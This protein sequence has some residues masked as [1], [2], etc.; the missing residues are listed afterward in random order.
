[1]IEL[2]TSNHLEAL[3]DALAGVVAEPLPSPFEPETIV[4]QSRGME[5][6]LSMRLAERFGLWANAEYPF[7]RALIQRVLEAAHGEEYDERS[8][9]DP[10][11]ATWS[12]IA[13]LDRAEGQPELAPLVDYLADDPLG[14]KRF[15]LADRI[16]HTFDQYLVYRP[17]M[18][19]EWDAGDGDGWQPILW[20]AA[21][22]ADASKHVADAYAELAAAMPKLTQADLPTRVSVF[23]VSSMP[24]MYLDVLDALSRRVPV[25]MF[26][27]NPSRRFWAHVRSRREIGRAVGKAGVDPETLHLEEGHPLLASLGRL[28]RELQTTLYRLDD[29]GEGPDLFAPQP[30]TSVLTTL[31]RDILDLLHRSPGGDAEPLP[32]EASDR[33]VAVH[34]CHSPMREVEVLWDQLRAI[35]DDAPELQPRDM[36]VMAPDIAAYAPYIEAV[37]AD[38]SIP[39]SITDRT[40]LDASPAVDGFLSLLGLGRS[41]FGATEILDLL[42][43]PPIRARFGLSA[44]AVEQ[45]RDWVQSAAIRWGIDEDHRTEDGHPAF[46]ENTWR[47]GLDR[48]LLGYASP[49]EGSQL[50]GATLAY[51]EIEGGDAV[52]LGKLADALEVLIAVARDLRT[53]RSVAEW[54]TRLDAMVSATLADDG[55]FAAE[56]QKIREALVELSEHAADAGYDA[57]IEVDALRYALGLRFRE[58][59]T[60]SGF[61][62]GGVTF[63][64]MLPMRSI[65]FGVVA[66]IGMNDDAYPRHARA[67]GFDLIAKHPRAG[68][69]SRR[70][71][72]RYLFLEALLSARERLLISYSGQSIRDNSSLPPSVVVSELVD[73]I[74]QGFELGPRGDADEHRRAIEARLVVAHPLQPFSPRYFVPDRPAELFSYSAGYCQGAAALR[75]GGRTP[76]PFLTGPLPAP[77]SKPVL[78]LDDLIAFFGNPAQFLLRNRLGIYLHSEDRSIDD[79]Q[80]IALTGL[81]GYGVG[82]GILKR[83][84]AGQAMAE[85]A[86]TARASGELPAGTPGDCAFE[87][88]AAE[89]T[90]LAGEIEPLVASERLPPVPVDIDVG[91]V[92]IVGWLSRVHPDAQIDWGFRRIRGKHQITGWIRHLALA[93]TLGDR[94]SILL[95]RS[96][97]GQPRRV[98]IAPVA[99]PLVHLESLVEIYAA[100]AS[101]P[102]P[103][104]PGP[105]LV[106]AELASKNVKSAV[107]AARGAYDKGRG[108]D[109]SVE[110]VFGDIDPLDPELRLF[111]EPT[112]PS[113]TFDTLAQRV[114]NGYIEHR[115]TRM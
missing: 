57:P 94:P 24:P 100:G 23:G 11:A 105:S 10:K 115:K 7:P 25:R 12:V 91:E 101:V 85:A 14:T 36:I 77:E 28:G 99:D 48:M 76:E 5:T 87:D 89:V 75:D 90:R 45:V 72:D 54:K 1:V 80:P 64:S 56:V 20:R 108:R 81:E 35:L 109:P 9:F 2:Y 106:Y 60:S 69:R 92:K 102:L 27:L 114:F 30:R 33:S 8:A 70:N 83:H 107:K 55:R 40:V 65:P 62:S 22:A 3:F 111:G 95:G 49:G 15:Q 13:Q 86:L 112:D 44:E 47:F 66:M 52:L 61:L 67:L 88:Y 97:S 42:E 103:F 93:A 73:T 63:C 82:A 16:A 32:L 21:R 84:L 19:R 71:E 51:D 6:W 41:R 29:I 18:I 39:F 59:L 98:D 26:L 38:G 68:D 53:P 43:R 74:A 79:Q 58:T 34:S 37:F 4:V 46:G 31:Q 96:G 17:E 104:F 113:R 110:R 78:E 50:F